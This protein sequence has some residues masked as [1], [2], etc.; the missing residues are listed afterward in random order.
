MHAAS[1]RQYFGGSMS[2]HG[3]LIRRV[4]R[5]PAEDMNNAEVLYF[6]WL[7]ESFAHNVC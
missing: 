7:A 4:Q 6:L 2:F 3:Q 1:Q 5:R